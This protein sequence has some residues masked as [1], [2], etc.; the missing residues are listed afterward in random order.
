[1]KCDAVAEQRKIVGKDCRRTAKRESHVGCDV[2]AVKLELR[3]KAVENKIEIQLADNAE[4]EFARRSHEIDWAALVE[5][6]D[7]AQI[8]RLVGIEP[9]FYASV[10][11]EK[12]RRN[13]KRSH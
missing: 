13:K 5:N 9:L 11:T 6:D 1:M 12:L 8:F 10:K 3:R 7:A 2:F 4:I